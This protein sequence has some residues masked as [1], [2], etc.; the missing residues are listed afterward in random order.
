MSWE[1]AGRE[2]RAL[3][4]LPPNVPGPLSRLLSDSWKKM[5]RAWVE[6]AD[7][8]ALSLTG[9]VA[10][11]ES[12]PSLLWASVFSS[13]KRIRPGSLIGLLQGLSGKTLQIS[14]AR[15]RSRD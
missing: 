10:P 5:E 15:S 6:S 2:L 9:C 13:V 1:G 11:S 12:L 7:P 8:R 4:M 14:G 3:A